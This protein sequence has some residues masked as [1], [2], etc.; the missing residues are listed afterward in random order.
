MRRWSGTKTD[1]CSGARSAERRRCEVGR[2]IKGQ[3]V[4]VGGERCFVRA[5]M[6]GRVVVVRYRDSAVLEVQCGDLTPWEPGT[7]EGVRDA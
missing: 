1:T 5:F 3:I 2:F 4:V 6:P 7:R